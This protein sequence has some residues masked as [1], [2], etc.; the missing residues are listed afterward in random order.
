MDYS[1]DFFVDRKGFTE[2]WPFRHLSTMAQE[3][4]EH[5][6]KFFRID[7]RLT[8]FSPRA[9]VSQWRAP[10]QSATKKHIQS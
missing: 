6:S 10:S 2:T 4:G 7:Y 9:Q 8:L 1:H 3:G 5:D